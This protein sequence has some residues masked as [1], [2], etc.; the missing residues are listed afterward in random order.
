[1][2][3]QVETKGGTERNNRPYSKEHLF[4]FPHLFIFGL[5]V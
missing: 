5:N 1:M 4:H 3:V 2:E